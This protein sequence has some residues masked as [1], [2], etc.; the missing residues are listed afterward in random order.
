MRQCRQLPGQSGIGEDL[1][2]VLLPGAGSF[3][4]FAEAVGLAQL[5]AHIGGGLGEARRCG[6]GAEQL[7]EAHFIVGKVGGT[8]GQALEHGFEFFALLINRVA[9]FPGRDV[10]LELH[11]AIDKPQV[12]LVM[13]EPFVGVD[14][15]V[16]AGPERDI[17][18]QFWRA[19]HGIGGGRG[20]SRLRGTCRAHPRETQDQERN[21]G[22]E[23]GAWP[24]GLL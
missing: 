9:A 19:E 16:D 1:S 17:A 15:G 3:Q 20:D 13:Q 21:Q 7:L 12:I 24:C 11:C 22:P 4:S 18:N 5:E 14:L 10:R 2:D 6:F 23:N 8:C